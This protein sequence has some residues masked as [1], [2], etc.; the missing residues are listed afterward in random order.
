[1]ID[2]YRIYLDIIGFWY[3][4]RTFLTSETYSWECSLSRFIQGSWFDYWIGV[5]FSDAGLFSSFDFKQR[6][7]SSFLNPG[8][9]LSRTYFPDRIL[10][11]WY[12]YL[13]FCSN[14]SEI[15]AF[16]HLCRWLNPNN[17]AYH[18]SQEP[19]RELSSHH[20]PSS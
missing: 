14:F 9:A 5:S 2:H 7:I 15:L 20:F 17:C 8:N 1:M 6:L 13:Y 12:D 4:H 10:P 18:F 3:L 19:D 16:I 11:L